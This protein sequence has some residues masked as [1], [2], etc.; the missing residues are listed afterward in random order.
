LSARCEVINHS[1]ICSCEQGYTGDPFTRCYQIPRNTSST[2]NKTDSN[3]YLTAPPRENPKPLV[4]NPCVP[5]PC[6]Q[7]SQCKDIRGVPSCSCLPNFIGSPPNCRPEC[8]INSE[9]SSNLACIN[10]KCKDPCPG[11]CGIGAVCEVRNHNPNCRCPA[12]Y[13]GDSFISCHLKPPPPQRKISC[14]HILSTILT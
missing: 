10:S 8:T 1:P 3:L 6:G 14:R 11:S 7:N 2:R 12:G 9:C 5:S 13:E 4:I